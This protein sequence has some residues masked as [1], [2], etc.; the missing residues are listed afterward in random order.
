MPMKSTGALFVI[1]DPLSATYSVRK[2]PGRKAIRAA[3]ASGSEEPAMR[4]GLL[5]SVATLFTGAS[6]ALAQSAPSGSPGTS[7]PPP[8][9]TS[10]PGG[11]VQPYLLHGD[12]PAPGHPDHAPAWDKGSDCW[13][14]GWENVSPSL[15][16]NAEY[17]VWWIKNGPLATPLV[18][19]GTTASQGIPGNPGTAALFGNGS[20]DYHTFSGGR[21]TLGLWHNNGQTIGMEASGFF[22]ENRTVNFD[23]ASTVTGSPVIARPFLNALTGT[24]SALLVSSPDAFTGGIA[25][26]STSNLYGWEVNAVGNLTRDDRLS[27]NLLVGFR[28]THLEEDL[29]V[30]QTSTLLP[31]GSLGF[32]GDI[33]VPPA[34]V[35]V[36]DRLATEND[37]YGGQLGAQAEYAAGNLFV[38]LLGKVALGATHQ[39]GSIGGSST[40]KRDG[41]PAM[42]LPGGLLAL[43]SNISQPTHDEFSIVPE[44]GVTAG[45]QV[46][47]WLRLS[48]GYSFLFWTN[49]ARP[50]SLVNPVVNPTLIP[51]SQAFAIA[52]GPV[53]P[54][55]SLTRSD[56]WAQ[57]VNFGLELRY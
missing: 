6:L 23:V 48:A 28:T 50:S 24:P 34:V 8:A 27:V 22:L 43:S 41:M 2:F 3:H 5:G 55:S 52:N 9:S 17:L 45:W 20:L 12:S 42:T 35:N 44:L 1:S 36:L 51:T 7:E 13:G 18:T 26:R 16:V 54:T 29:N 38:R 25:I 21:F 47:P 39:A 31:G 57:G 4:Q 49:V 53:Q 46:C 32:A 56:F 15:W 19:V 37:F 33:I 40:L 11:T 30:R 10:L 14:P